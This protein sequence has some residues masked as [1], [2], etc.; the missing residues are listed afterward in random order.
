MTKRDV[1]R[2]LS[3]WMHD[4]ATGCWLW[5]AGTDK[6]G[7]GKFQTGR[8]KA[9]RHWR[10]TRFAVTAATGIEPKRCEVVRHTCDTPACVNPAHLRVGTQK[11]NIAD[12]DSRGRRPSGYERRA[13]WGEKHHRAALTNA[14]AAEIRRRYRPRKGVGALAQEFGISRNTVLAIGTGKA[15]RDAGS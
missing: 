12:M 14:Q 2:F 10:A 9:Q 11:E 5:T 8:H 7:Y 13:T 1:Q 3:K 4:P 6:D 15:Y